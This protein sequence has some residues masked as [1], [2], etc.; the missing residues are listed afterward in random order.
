MN[1]NIKDVIFGHNGVAKG[2]EIPFLDPQI[3]KIFNVVLEPKTTKFSSKISPKY[4]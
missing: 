4:P 1:N 2:R 3:F